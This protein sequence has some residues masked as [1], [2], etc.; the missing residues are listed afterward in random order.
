M[1][2]AMLI[3]EKDNVIVAIEPLSKGT[4]AVYQVNGRPEEVKVLAD[5]HMYHKIARF[6]IKA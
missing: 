6:P 2:N 3:N 4:K 1:R 5:I